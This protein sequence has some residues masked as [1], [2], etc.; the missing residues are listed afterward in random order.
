MRNQ[1]LEY[2]KMKKKTLNFKSANLAGMV[3]WD[4][5]MYEW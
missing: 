1:I 4:L 2:T 5:N 3:C